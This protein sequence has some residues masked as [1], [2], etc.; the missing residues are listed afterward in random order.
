[1]RKSLLSTLSREW[2]WLA[3]QISQAMSPKK[4][5]LAVSSL[6]QL[7]GQLGVVTAVS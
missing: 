1:M 6:S 5:L 3:G 4:H 2:R 7:A